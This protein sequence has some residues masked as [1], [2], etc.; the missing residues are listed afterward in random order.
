L[1]DGIFAADGGPFDF[2]LAVAKVGGVLTT[3]VLR[4]AFVPFAIG[5]VLG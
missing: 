4:S 2:F 3:V 5:Y 1:L